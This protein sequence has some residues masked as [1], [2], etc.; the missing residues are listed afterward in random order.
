MPEPDPLV[1]L[2]GG[3]RHGDALLVDWGGSDERLRLVGARIMVYRGG[4]RLKWASSGWLRDPSGK[5]LYA[6]YLLSLLAVDDF[7]YL[8]AKACGYDVAVTDHDLKTH[9]QF[10][11]VELVGESSRLISGD[12]ISF[13]LQGK[14]VQVSRPQGALDMNLYK[15]IGSDCVFGS[16][17][18]YITMSHH[19]TVIARAMAEA[20]G[21]MASPVGGDRFLLVH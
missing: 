3:L 16:D 9:R 11:L 4:A 7:V 8:L 18:G 6:P 19:P 15:P 21:L 13:D 20:N 14:T 1:V 10:V 17:V 12:L 2:N 5:C